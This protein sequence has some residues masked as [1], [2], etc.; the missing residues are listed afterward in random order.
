MSPLQGAR[1]IR[2]ALADWPPE[3]MRPMRRDRRGAGMITR[4]LYRL[5][6]PDAPH[7]AN[8]GTRAQCEEWRGRDPVGQPL[9]TYLIAPV[10]YCSVCGLASALEECPA[11]I[12]WDNGETRCRRHEDRNPCVVEGCMRTRASKGHPLSDAHICGEHWRKYVPPRSPERRALQRMFRLA[13]KAGFNR[14]TRWSDDLERRY[15]R[16]WA[17]VVQRGRRRSSAGHIDEAAIHRLFGWDEQ[18]VVV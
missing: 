6:H 11:C 4:D 10:A 14:N 5:S 12:T 1:P 18:G 9:E 3:A 8:I 17:A 16:I 13:K 2:H 7:C 15:W